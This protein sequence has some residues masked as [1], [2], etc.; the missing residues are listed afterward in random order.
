MVVDAHSGR[1]QLA[2]VKLTG[3]PRESVL[4][5]DH[6]WRFCIGNHTTANRA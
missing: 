4:G 6:H 2:V 5:H 1:R 3:S